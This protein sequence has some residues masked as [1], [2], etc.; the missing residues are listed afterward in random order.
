MQRTDNLVSNLKFEGANCTRMGSIWS[1]LFFSFSRKHLIS[2]TQ[3]R[4]GINIIQIFLVKT[5]LINSELIGSQK[6][7]QQLYN[8]S[9]NK[10]AFS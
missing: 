2:H 3:K 5:G 7:K 1:E 6:P 8:Y 4:I 9:E 10:K